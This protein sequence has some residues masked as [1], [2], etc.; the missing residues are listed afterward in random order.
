MKDGWYNEEFFA[1]YES[2][3]EAERATALYRLSEQLPGYLVIGL[4]F[5]D[6]FIV[7]NSEDRYF[8]VPTVPAVREELR[9]YSFPAEPM[10]LRHDAQLSGKIKWYIQP[11]VFSGSP[12]KAKNMTWIS[13][14]QHAE[15]VVY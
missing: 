14:D 9:P 11:I 7:C 8:T 13:H 3:E 4:R 2:R 10:N 6:D 15:A 1:L 5:W 12:S